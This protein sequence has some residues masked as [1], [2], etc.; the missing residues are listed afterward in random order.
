[1]A[2]ELV[3]QASITVGTDPVLISEEQI[4][5]QRSVVF[6][7]NQSTGGQVIS[8]SWELAPVAG[9]GVVLG[10]GGFVQDSMDS[11]YKPSNKRIFAVAS[12]AGG[13]LAVHER[14]LQ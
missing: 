7:S 5:P 9:Q 6:L 11:G 1:M 4:G 8:I 13:T 10:V 12:A 14:V 3:R 2:N